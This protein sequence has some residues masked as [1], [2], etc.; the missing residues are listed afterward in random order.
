MI[1]SQMFGARDYVEC[2]A[3]TDEGVREALQCA[4]RIALAQGEESNG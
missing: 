1:A 4:S 2:S 3:K